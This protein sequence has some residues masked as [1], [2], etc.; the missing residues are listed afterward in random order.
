MK[1]TQKEQAGDVRIRGDDVADER[2]GDVRTRGDSGCGATGEWAR[3]EH[4]R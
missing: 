1:T 3:C 2:V 4:E